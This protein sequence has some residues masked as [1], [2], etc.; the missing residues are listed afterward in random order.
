MARPSGQL[1]SGLRR[2]KVDGGVRR[3]VVLPCAGSLFAEINVRAPIAAHQAFFLAYHAT[4]RAGFEQV[5]YNVTGNPA[6]GLEGLALLPNLFQLAL[7][8]HGGLPAVL[9]T[10]E[11]SEGQAAEM[12]PCFLMD[13]NPLVFNLLG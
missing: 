10:F 13:V 1:L 12:G 3:H 9:N 6:P 7:P 5:S 2:P 8:E 4:S 11:Q